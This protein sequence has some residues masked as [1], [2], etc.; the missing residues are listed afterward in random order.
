MG[1]AGDPDIVPENAEVA[2]A[3]SAVTVR[4]FIALG[5]PAGVQEGIEA[6]TFSAMGR[7][8]YPE[9]SKAYILK[10]SKLSVE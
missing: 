9:F 7:V 10:A 6:G 1:I 4:D 2:I 3:R 8:L 5:G